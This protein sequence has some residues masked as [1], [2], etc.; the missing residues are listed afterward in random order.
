MPPR[1]TQNSCTAAAVAEDPQQS[2]HSHSHTPVPEDPPI[3]NNLDPE[4]NQEETA[5]KDLT[6]NPLM[7]LS[8]AVREQT[9]TNSAVGALCVVISLSQ[10]C[11][12][13]LLFY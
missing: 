9:K 4:A 11:R 5:D 12:A 2:V 1:S 10:Q 7:S 8:V 3:I 13:A 6:E